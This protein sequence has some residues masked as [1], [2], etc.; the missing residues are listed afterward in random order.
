MTNIMICGV[1]GQGLVLTSGII[2]EVIKR[3]GFDVKSN[4]VIG[5][6]QRGGRVWANVRF[7]E[8]VYSPNIDQGEADFLLAF[9]P[10]EG[11]RA[12]MMLKDNGVILMNTKKI[13]P[14]DVVFEKAEY[15]EEKIEEMLQKYESYSVD[16]SLKGI[17]IG[18]RMISNTIL[19][20]MLAKKL[21]VDV[22][23]WREVI[24]EKVPKKAL[25]FNIKAFEFGYEFVKQEGK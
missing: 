17:E 6:S 25:D 21:P 16:A 4:D 12:I 13:Y 7:G 24:S 20:G 22:S 19:L 9:E 5:L 15:P 3:A 2:V 14:S 11:L 1:G 23:L 18:N 10:L 8:R